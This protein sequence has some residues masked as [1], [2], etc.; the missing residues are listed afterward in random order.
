MYLFINTV[1]LLR[2][3]GNVELGMLFC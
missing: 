3:Y 2:N 1:I